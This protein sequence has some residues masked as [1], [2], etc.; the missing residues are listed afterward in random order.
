LVF[1]LRVEGTVPM[2]FSGDETC[3][4]AS[5]TASP[6]TDDYTSESS[7]FTSSIE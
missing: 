6:V 2:M 7:G 4:V 5:A 1:I 3:D